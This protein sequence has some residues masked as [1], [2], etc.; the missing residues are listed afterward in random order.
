MAQEDFFSKSKEALSAIALAFQLVT[1]EQAES[2]SQAELASLLDHEQKK[3]EQAQ[4][5]KASAKAPAKSKKA[6]AKKK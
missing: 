5:T 4:D 6:P 2:M 1:P 3:S